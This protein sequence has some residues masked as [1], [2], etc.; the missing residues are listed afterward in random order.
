MSAKVAPV[1]YTYAGQGANGTAG[2]NNIFVGQ[3]AT[4]GAN[5]YA[6]GWSGYPSGNYDGF[7]ANQTGVNDLTVLEIPWEFNFRLAKL[8]ARLF[9]DYAY[10]LE[11][12]ERANAAFN[13]ANNPPATVNLTGIRPI[14]SAQTKDI[15]AYQVGFALGN[16]DLGLVYGTTSKK[17]NW[18]TRVYWQHIEQ[19]ALDPNLLDSDFFEG[20]GNL[21]GIFTAASYC[22]TD[23]VLGTLRYGYA[24]RINK[25]LGTGG[26][27][28][29]IP[30]M[31]PI[32]H[33]QLIQLDLTLRF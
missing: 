8:N 31:N 28:Q 27:N 13:A 10:N 30:Q 7:N 21:E 5:G 15:H 16:G 18:E 14:S 22:F 19:Y 6:Y 11:G 23:N 1:L 4:N 33:Y 25:M 17:H 9:G 3:G 29:D 32:E 20:R 24:N 26:S 12:S 2:F